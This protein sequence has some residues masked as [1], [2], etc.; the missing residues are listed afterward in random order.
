MTISKFSLKFKKS[1]RNHQLE[2]NALHTCVSDGGGEEEQDDCGGGEGGD[3]QLGVGG[4]ILS[5]RQT[6]PAV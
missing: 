2:D 6:G 4:G 1:P 5:L 3:D